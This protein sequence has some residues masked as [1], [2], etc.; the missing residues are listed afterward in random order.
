[1]HLSFLFYLALCKLV[2]FIILCSDAFFVGWCGV[3]IVLG[4]TREVN[5]AKLI[6]LG[7]QGENSSISEPFCSVRGF[8]YV[9]V[10]IYILDL[11]IYKVVPLFW[12]WNGFKCFNAIIFTRFSIYFPVRWISHCFPHVEMTFPFG[13][14]KGGKW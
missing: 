9:C 3:R 6:I 14:H 8:L 7:G 11:Y 10:I 1:V 13:E 12:L 2:S 4:A 5:K